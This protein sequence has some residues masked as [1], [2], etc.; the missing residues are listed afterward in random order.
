MTEQEQTREGRVGERVEIKQRADG[1]YQWTKVYA[2]NERGPWIG[3]GLKDLDYAWGSASRENPGLPL[4]LIDET[5]GIIEERRPDPA[6]VPGAVPGKP[7]G[8]GE[9]LTLGDGRTYVVTVVGRPDNDGRVV[10]EVQH[11]AAFTKDQETPA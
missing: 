8:K 4:L 5:G 3:E 7:F 1:Q 9:R 10:I 2:N 11:E 6:Q